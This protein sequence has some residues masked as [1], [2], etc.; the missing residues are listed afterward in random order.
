MLAEHA[1]R[2][3]GDSSASAPDLVPARLTELRRN[4]SPERFSRLIAAGRQSVI[5]GAQTLA[6]AWRKRDL[7]RIAFQAH[8]LRSAAGTAGM[9]ALQQHVAAVEHAARDG[10]DSELEALMPDIASLTSAALA[11]LEAW[12]N[13]GGHH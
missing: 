6:D 2:V 10:K 7:A 13:D 8:R 1:G 9:E 12:Q 5:E 3:T 11:A 4:M